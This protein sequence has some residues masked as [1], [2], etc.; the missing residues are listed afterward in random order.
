MFRA[1]LYGLIWIFLVAFVLLFYIGVS[2]IFLGQDT[3]L[4]HTQQLLQHEVKQ[5]SHYKKC[6]DIYSNQIS[7]IKNCVLPTDIKIFSTLMVMPSS[8]IGKKISQIFNTL[9]QLL[10]LR[11]QLCMRFLPLFGLLGVVGFVDGFTQRIL[12]RL[13]GARESSVLYHRARSMLMPSLVGGSV[14]YLGLPISIQPSGLFSSFAFLF[15]F[16]LSMAVRTYKKYL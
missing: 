3:V 7:R 11:L 14:L 4:K 12:R 6:A 5:L 15:S 2:Q 13:Q 16:I 8:L 10:F 1:C 9:F